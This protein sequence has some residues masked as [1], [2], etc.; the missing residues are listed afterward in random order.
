MI[1]QVNICSTNP[2]AGNNQFHQIIFSATNA[3]ICIIPNFKN[4]LVYNIKISANTSAGDNAIK[5]FSVHFRGHNNDG[6]QIT[7]NAGIINNPISGDWGSAF[8]KDTVLDFILTSKKP[9]IVFK[10]P[11]ILGGFK[12]VATNLIFSNVLAANRFTRFYLTV[13]Y[14]TLTNSNI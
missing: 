11:I 1:S 7:E 9:E 5:Y 3:A 6:S 14:E 13:N 2:S 8:V 4:V 12:P 10:Q